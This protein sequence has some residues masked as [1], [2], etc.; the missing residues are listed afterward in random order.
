MKI[1]EL[2]YNTCCEA[3]GIEIGEKTRKKQYVKARAVYYKI[4]KE[5]T[6]LSLEEI[7]RA[8]GNRDHATVLHGL[9]KYDA[10]M[11]YRDFQSFNKSIRSKLP[12]SLKEFSKFDTKDER[13]IKFLYS[14][15]ARLEK[16]NELL[17]ARVLSK[18]V[19]KEIVDIFN[20]IPSEMLEN[21][22]EYR[23][24]PFIKMNCKPSASV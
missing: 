22:L 3:T 24:K 18:N 5:N 23:I 21:L 9:K 19:E 20:A 8:C 6:K 15:K 17:K 4:A 13:E 7:G 12:S 10:E 2:I 16:Q 14:N 11:Q 1:L